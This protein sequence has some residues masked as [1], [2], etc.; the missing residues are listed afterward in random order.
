[1]V[2]D[3]F[4]N[5][6]YIGGTSTDLLA[7]CPRIDDNPTPLSLYLFK[8]EALVLLKDLGITIGEKGSAV[9]GY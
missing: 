4:R 9:E 3:S 5:I 7:A 2:T 1:M 8:P 6:K